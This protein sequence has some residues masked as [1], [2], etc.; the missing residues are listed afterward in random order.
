MRQSEHDDNLFRG[1][2][3]ADLWIYSQVLSETGGLPYVSGE[4][5]HLH[6]VSVQNDIITELTEYQHSV[7]MNRELSF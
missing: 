1:P 2:D 5:L 3:A 6:Y 4:I 7:E